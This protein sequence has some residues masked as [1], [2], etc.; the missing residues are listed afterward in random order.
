MEN[1]SRYET[2][3]Q[4]MACLPHRFPFLMVDAVSDLAPGESLTAL[5][6]VSYADCPQGSPFASEFLIELLGQAAILLFFSDGTQRSDRVQTLL[7]G[8]EQFAFHGEAR[9]GETLEARVRFQKLIAN[10]A[11]IEG[12]VF[13]R[14]RLIAEGQLSAAFVPKAAKMPTALQI[15]GAAG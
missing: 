9:Q 6:Q 15:A 12:S 4:I 10:A 14:G 8:V 2:A 7:V 5:K 3:Q 1:V 11:I 13:V